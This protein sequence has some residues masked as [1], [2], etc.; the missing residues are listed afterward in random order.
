MKWKIKVT[1]A[2]S[3]WLHENVTKSYFSVIFM[4]PM[5]EISM[6]GNVETV[7]ARFLFRIYY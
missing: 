3:M 7:M 4:L 5:R 2:D 1:V 6:V